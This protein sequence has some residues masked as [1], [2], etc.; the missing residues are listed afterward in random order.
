MSRD[1]TWQ[2]RGES[3]SRISDRELLWLPLSVALAFTLA[4]L[5]DVRPYIAL[6]P[7]ALLFGWTQMGGWCGTAH[8]NTMSFLWRSNRRLGLRATLAYTMAGLVSAVTIGTL[9]GVL[10]GYSIRLMNIP[11]L[12]I[13]SFELT[14]LFAL[15]LA[16]RELG[17]IRFSLVG[18]KCQTNRNWAYEFGFVRAASMWGFHIGLG[19]ATVITYGGFW[20]LVSAIVAVGSPTFGALV[21]GVYW[22]GRSLP[23]WLVSP[24]IGR[25]WNCEAKTQMFRPAQAIGLI[26][27]S[28]ASVLISGMQ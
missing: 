22:L 26:C 7:L 25:P 4:A 23:L 24:F 16:A 2:F 6:L 8:V 9:L 3:A 15:I 5:I 19:F 17:W 14:T 10:G 1:V 28:V 20:F 21:M 12:R 13:P 11:Q 18:A 27:G